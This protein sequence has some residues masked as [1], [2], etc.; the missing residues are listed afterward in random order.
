[1]IDFHCHIDLYPD[2]AA[3]IREV[4]ADGI[5]VLAVTTTPK[6]WSH[7]QQLICGHKRIKAAIGLHPELVAERFGEVE[8][9]CSIAK[10]TRYVGEI[11]LDGSPS[12]KDSFA[13]QKQVFERILERCCELGG[14]ILSVHSKRAATEV[15]NSLEA[16]PKSGKTVLHW[17]SGTR[18]ELERAIKMD[19][20]FS[21]G[22]A[23]LRSAKGRQLIGAMPRSRLLT[24]SDGPFARIGSSPILPNNMV[25]AESDIAKIWKT[26]PEDVRSKIHENF[27]SLVTGVE[28]FRD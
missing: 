23:M 21:V 27:R 13:L 10:E 15:L 6:S 25:E 19:A 3:L 11:G 7:L 28:D 5:Y 8:E 12:L 1:M 17:F 2:P 18:T 26:T 20:W 9:V 14:R 24:E 16:F 4:G 22:P